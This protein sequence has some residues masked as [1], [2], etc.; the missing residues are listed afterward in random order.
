M[1]IHSVFG[2]FFTIVSGFVQSLY[3]GRMFCVLSRRNQLGD[4]NPIDARE[5]LLLSVGGGV[6]GSNIAGI[7][8]DITLGRTGG[9]K[10]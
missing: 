1:G 5:A 10:D 4:P 9:N 8:V 2:V 3:F 7:A 6:G